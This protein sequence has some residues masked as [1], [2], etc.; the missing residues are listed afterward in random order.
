MIWVGTV[1]HRQAGGTSRDSGNVPGRHF[2]ALLFPFLGPLVLRDDCHR[3]KEIGTMPNPREARRWF[4]RRNGRRADASPQRRYRPSVERLERFLLLSTDVVTNTLDFGVGSLY[5]AI[6][7]VDSRLANVID[8]DIAGG[9]MKV[10]DMAGLPAITAQVKIDG[11]SQPGYSGSPLIELNGGSATTA[12]PGLNLS[13]GSDGSSV[14]GL[15][16]TA[17]S[18][19]R[20]RGRLLAQHDWRF[21][22][23]WQRHL[24]QW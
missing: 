19:A 14:M 1:A 4:P 9:G 12:S 23:R 13:S 5:Q 7:D 16:I 2:P 8:F 3:E 24:V 18:G 15:F 22:E 11:T 21:R 20:D 10:I 17:W 6:E